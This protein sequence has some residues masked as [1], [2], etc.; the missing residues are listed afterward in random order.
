MVDST[1]RFSKQ[2]TGN[3]GTVSLME[4]LGAALNER[5][6]MILMGGGNPAHIPAVEACLAKHW[7]MIGDDAAAFHKVIGEY[8]TP[9][10]DPEFLQLLADLLRRECGWDI[11]ADNIA[12]SNGGQSAFFILFNMLAGEGA[13]GEHKHIQLPMAPEYL[14]YADV[15]LNDNMFVATAPVIQPLGEREFK[16]GI[17]FDRFKIHDDTA[18]VCLSRPTNPTGNIVTDAEL[19]QLKQLCRE[20]NIPLI[21]DVAYGLPFP[22]ITFVEHSVAWD[23]DTILVMTLSK[24]GLP[25]V[26]TGIVIAKKS[27]IKQ[28]SRATASLSLAPG[29]LGPALGKSLIRSGDLLRLSQTHVQPFYRQKMQQ[30]LAYIKQQ[31]HSFPVS[32]HKPEGALFLWLWFDQLPITSHVLYER[33][34]ARG[35]MVLSGHHFFKA[36]PLNEREQWPHSQQCIRMNYC[37]PWDKVKAGIDLICDEI[38][39]LYR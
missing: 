29:S 9:Q 33:L 23:E 5:S 26:R 38:A 24:L 31:M 35:V 28:F 6:D 22:G 3:S 12:I 11:S 8:Q 10:G 2:Y 7:Q 20:K 17:D 16:Y 37:Q 19:Q 4:D 34:K 15:G 14:G 39:Q 30:T 27:T 36:L 32:I 18:A 21:L 25:G 13:S 1:S